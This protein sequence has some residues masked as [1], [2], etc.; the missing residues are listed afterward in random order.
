MNKVQNYE[1][2]ELVTLGEKD[3]FDKLPKESFAIQNSP[4]F[5]TF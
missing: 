4:M 3:A 1:T 5:V 2:I